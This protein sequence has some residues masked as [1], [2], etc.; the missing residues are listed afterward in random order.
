MVKRL[1]DIIFSVL[2]LLLLGWLILILFIAVS[3]IFKENGLFRQI[4]VG[5]YGKPF[6]I[7]KLRTMDSESFDIPSFAAFLRKHKLDEL[8]QF[9]NVLLGD[10]SV[11]GPRPD[12]PGYYDK[13]IGES[14]KI[15]ELKPGLTGLASIKYRHEESLLAQQSNPLQYNDEI[16]F[17]DKVRINLEY[18]YKQSLWVDLKIIWKT[19]LR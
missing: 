10:M 9:I 12:V 19:I 1:L 11:V 17:P 4:R 14:R 16:I 7:W 8:P 15:L 13:L 5:Q 2:G 3:I 6:K 18:Y